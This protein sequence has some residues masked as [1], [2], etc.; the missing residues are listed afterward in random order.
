MKRSAFRVPIVFWITLLLIRVAFGQ[1]SRPDQSA[2]LLKADELTSSAMKLYKE[3][4]Y[5]DVLPLVKQALEL[6]E[7][8]EGLKHP[9]L[10]PLLLI[11]GESSEARKSLEDAHLYFGRA[12]LIAEKTY[13]REDVSLATFLDRVAGVAYEQSDDKKA[14]KLLLRSLA[15][16]EK[17]F[18]ADHPDLAWTAFSLGQIYSLRRDYGKAAPFYQQAVRIREKIGGQDQSDLIRSLEKYLVA[19][20]A[21]DRNDEATQVQNRIGVLSGKRA[22]IQEGGV[23]NGKALDL[24]RP[25][26]PLSAR[27]EHASGKVQV[28]ILIDENGN[29]ISA[30]AVNANRVHPD[31]VYSA[32]SAALKARFSPTFLEGVPVKVRG[33]ITYNFAAQ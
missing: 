5:V 7:K 13:T 16:R 11:L 4:K 8:V 27:K 10:L 22:I 17:A 21:L 24:P 32:E 31:L 26:Y 3:R 12:L 1:T 25:S 29:V 14:E 6:R 20:V 18:G 19:L 30:R 33:M 28:Q 23:L 15:L 9:D 2:D